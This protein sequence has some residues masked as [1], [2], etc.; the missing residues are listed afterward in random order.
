MTR[1]RNRD[2]SKTLRVTPRV[3]IGR[4]L[5]EP[6]SKSRIGKR[7]PEKPRRVMFPSGQL[8]RRIISSQDISRHVCPTCPRNATL[9][10]RTIPSGRFCCPKRQTF[11]VRRY[12]TRTVLRTRT[13]YRIRTATAI[14]NVRHESPRKMSDLNLTVF[15]SLQRIRGRCTLMWI[16]L[17]PTIRALTTRWQA[18]LLC[19]CVKRARRL[20]EQ[21]HATR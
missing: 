14:S 8:P 11:F 2:V 4:F 17:G 21:K 15:S 20:R 7:N 13:V 16:A 10:A 19:L 5:E 6:W 3:E 1:T 9:D 18:S 12:K